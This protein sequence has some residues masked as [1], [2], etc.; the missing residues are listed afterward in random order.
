MALIPIV[1]T[2]NLMIKP[3]T[4]EMWVVMLESENG[5]KMDEVYYDE[6]VKME[7]PTL[8]KARRGAYIGPIGRPMG[9]DGLPMGLGPD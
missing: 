5:W 7:Q 4:R 3:R 9:Y 6:C 2:C 1:D 8:S